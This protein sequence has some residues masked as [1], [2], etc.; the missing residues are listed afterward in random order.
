MIANIVAAW[1]VI[2]D[3]DFGFDSGRFG[4]GKVLMLNG[5]V[6]GRN[7]EGRMRGVG[8]AFVGGRRELELRE[9]EG[10]RRDKAVLVRFELELR[11][12]MRT[13]VRTTWSVCLSVCLFFVDGLAKRSKNC[14]SILQYHQD[15]VR[16]HPLPLRR[17]TLVKDQ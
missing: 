16:S 2:L 8:E 5:R 6:P 1:I 7:S 11:S 10:S 9:F 17:I 13:R 12:R 3:L 15:L 4:R 14:W